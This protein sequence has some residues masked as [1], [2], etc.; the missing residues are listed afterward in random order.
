MPK[1]ELSFDYFL[2]TPTAEAGV[3]EKLKKANCA[4]ILQ[5]KPRCQNAKSGSFLA[6]VCQPASAIDRMYTGN[7]FF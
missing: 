2:G 1:V 3:S 5:N 7:L 4:M 6:T